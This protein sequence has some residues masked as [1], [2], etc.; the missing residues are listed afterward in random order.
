MS[1]EEQVLR[2]ELE[3]LA[4]HPQ[5][6]R[7]LQLSLR[8]LQRDDRELAVGCWTRRNGAGCLFQHAYW[9]GLDDGTMQRCS[10]AN[11]SIE[12]FMGGAEY[13]RV[14]RVIGAFDRLGRR[15][16]RIRTRGRLGLPRRVLAQ[17]R[18]RADVERMLLDALGRTTRVARAGRAQRVPGD[19]IR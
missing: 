5:G 1:A 14:V 7:L 13:A 10:S 16:Y 17:D 15:R 4:A 6:R 2:R 3:T 19:P 11:E 8:G 9:Q 12:R 18:W